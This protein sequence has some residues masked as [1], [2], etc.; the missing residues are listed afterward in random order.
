MN[1]YFDKLNRKFGSLYVSRA[2]SF[3]SN[4]KQKMKLVCMKCR[5]ID[6]KCRFSNSIHSLCKIFRTNCRSNELP[7]TN[8]RLDELSLDELP[9]N[10]R[11]IMVTPLGNIKKYIFN[12][13]SSQ[14]PVVQCSTSQYSIYQ[15][16][17]TD[18]FALSTAGIPMAMQ[19]VSRPTSRT[20]S[21]S[22]RRA[23][24][25]PRGAMTA[26]R[27]GAARAAAILLIACQLP[28]DPP[29][30]TPTRAYT[31][32]LPAAGDPNTYRRRLNTPSYHSVSVSLF[33][34]PSMPA[35]PSLEQSVIASVYDWWWGSVFGNDDDYWFSVRVIF[36]RWCI[37]E[38][39]V[40]F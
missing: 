34:C 8:C 31:H 22:A 19:G 12:L 9:W 6:V 21:R 10:P 17:L 2:R 36:S 29:S 24:P 16:P 1:E 35:C 27:A 38:V 14:C 3:Q 33:V 28:D 18:F 11:V 37:C 32:P 4:F 39:L 30:T 40:L 20:S 13:L 5:C 26:S 7:W 25:G 23:S 15:H